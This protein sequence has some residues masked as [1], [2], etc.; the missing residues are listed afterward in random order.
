MQQQ[1]LFTMRM[2]KTDKQ[3]PDVLELLA[4]DPASYRGG[5]P[6]WAAE[7]GRCYWVGAVAAQ[8]AHRFIEF[9]KRGDVA[10][11]TESQHVGQ[12]LVYAVLCESLVEPEVSVLRVIESPAE[13]SAPE[14]S[15]LEKRLCG[16]H[17]RERRHPID[18]DRVLDLEVGSIR[19]TWWMLLKSYF[20]WPR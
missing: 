19:P 9:A 4:W 3:N 20:R 1:L 16:L 6:S 17:L 11:M 8:D 15:I 2:S 5:T 7:L 14:I 13:M 18:A 10:A 12:D